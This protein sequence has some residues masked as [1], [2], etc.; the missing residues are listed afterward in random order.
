MICSENGT[1]F[2][3]SDFILCAKNLNFLNSHK[4]NQVQKV[5][6]LYFKIETSYHFI[7]RKPVNGQYIK[8]FI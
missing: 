7:R 5:F 4:I 3:K 8:F 1:M 6:K 2:C